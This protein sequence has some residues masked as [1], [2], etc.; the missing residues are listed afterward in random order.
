[1]KIGCQ[2][3]DMVH[4]HAATP[5]T[6]PKYHVISL[7]LVPPRLELMNVME[8]D[9]CIYECIVGVLD[10]LIHSNDCLQQLITKFPE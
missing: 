4:N 9:R 1:M 8:L 2:H 3:K 10:Q 7:H 6:H 5:T